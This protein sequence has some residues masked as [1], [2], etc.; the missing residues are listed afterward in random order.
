[1]TRENTILHVGDK[2][3]GFVLPDVRTGRN[4]VLADLLGRPLLVYFAR[5][6]WCPTCRRWMGIIA[7]NMPRIEQLGASA[8]T[9]MAQRRERMQSD[10]K[11]ASFPFPILCDEGRTVVK[12][13]GVWVKANFESIN[14]ARPANFVLGTDGTIRF[15]HIASVQFEYAPLDEIL[16]A[17]AE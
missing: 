6:T 5:G 7:E 16:T 8:V 12:E 9:I 15:I 10:L 17:L 3:P 14:I 2:A 13:W 4:A 11:D 1:M